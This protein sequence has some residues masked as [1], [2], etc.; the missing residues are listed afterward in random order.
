MCVYSVILCVCMGYGYIVNKLDKFRRFQPDTVSI[1]SVALANFVSQYLH[2]S[3]YFY[4]YP[5]GT[6]HLNLYYEFIRFDSVIKKKK[7]IICQRYKI[8]VIDPV[9]VNTVIRVILVTQRAVEM[10]MSAAQ[11]NQKNQSF[12]VV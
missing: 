11:K 3:F 10:A 5:Q 2:I 4:Y 12:R 9:S 1:C 7:K 6:I 8:K